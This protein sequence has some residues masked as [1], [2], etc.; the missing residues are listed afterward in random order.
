M[1]GAAQRTDPR[2]SLVL[3]NAEIA[4]LINRS[5]AQ[6]YL[7]SHRPDFPKPVAVLAMGTVWPGPEVREY[8]REHGYDGRAH[9]PGRS[10]W[11]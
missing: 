7:I 5:R 9:S 3:G 6:V 4:S 11:R 2:E 8:L 10:R 1:S